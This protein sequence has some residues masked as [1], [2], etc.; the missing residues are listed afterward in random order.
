MNLISGDEK[1]FAVFDDFLP[2]ETLRQV[3]GA[4]ATETMSFVQSGVWRRAFKL[5]DGNPL[6]GTGVLYGHPEPPDLRLTFPTDRPIDLVIEALLRCRDDLAPWVGLEG[7]DWEF[8][9][10]TPYIYPVG[11]GLSWHED[12]A[13]RSGSFVLYV[14]PEWQVDWGGELLVGSDNGTGAYVG[15][16]PNRLVVIKSGV[17]HCIKKVD[18]SAGSNVRASVTGFFQRIQST[19]IPH[20]ER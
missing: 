1:S 15:P 9:S 2:P 17:H 4:F 11:S 10:A 20:Q 3:W 14:H 18:I 6:C 8:M 16:R 19:Q 13:G 7:F 12:T 5:T